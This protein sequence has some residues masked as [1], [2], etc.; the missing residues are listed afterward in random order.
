MRRRYDKLGVELNIVNSPADTVVVPADF[1]F[2]PVV[3][4]ALCTGP[5]ISAVFVARAPIAAT[6]RPRGGAG[7]VEDS[8]TRPAPPVPVVAGARGVLACSGRVRNDPGTDRGATGA[9]LLSPT[10]TRE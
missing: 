3:V 10:D 5:T 1:T 2:T 8:F 6:A 7:F 4:D 9:G